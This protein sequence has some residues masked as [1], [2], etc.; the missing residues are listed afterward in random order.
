MLRETKDWLWSLCG[1][2]LAHPY[3]LCSLHGGRSDCEACLHMSPAL[4]IG[5]ADPLCGPRSAVW[6]RGRADVS[7][8]LGD[9]RLALP[10]PAERVESNIETL[11]YL[12]SIS[13]LEKGFVELADNVLKTSL[14]LTHECN[15][16]DRDL[17]SEEFY[18][19][20]ERVERQLAQQKHR[21]HQSLTDLRTQQPGNKSTL[22][23]LTDCIHETLAEMVQFYIEWQKVELKCQI[24]APLHRRMPLSPG[25]HCG[26]LLNSISLPNGEQLKSGRHV[27]VSANKPSDLLHREWVVEDKE[28]H[29]MSTV[30]APFVWLSSA[31]ITPVQSP[32]NSPVNSRR[33]TPILLDASKPN[34]RMAVERFV[35][36]EILIFCHYTLLGITFI[37]MTE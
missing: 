29:V 24:V 1:R 26:V 31:D 18:L 10:S 14:E 30:P 6:M 27:L 5:W 9:L 15:K 23:N 13:C 4:I 37:K 19:E 11:D 2:P 21:L 7:P 33:S 22:S 20:L 16:N 34:N 3:D 25:Q 8:R 35:T 12:R 17:V 28:S 32:K 36:A